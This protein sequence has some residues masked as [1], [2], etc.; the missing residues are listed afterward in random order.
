MRKLGNAH[1]KGLFEI[2]M[3]IKLPGGR[4]PVH[5]LP[6]LTAT[7]ARCATRFDPRKCQSPQLYLATT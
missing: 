6:K 4:K 5:H 2:D 3:G 7:T 1:R